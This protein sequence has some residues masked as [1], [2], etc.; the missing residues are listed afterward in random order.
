MF[1][2]NLLSKYSFMKNWKW[3]R[4]KQCAL[5]ITKSIVF[6]FLDRYSTLQSEVQRLKDKESNYQQDLQRLQQST[7][8]LEKVRYQEPYFTYFHSIKYIYR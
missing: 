7:I 8:A 4:L 2:L 5:R 3:N 6:L 1:N